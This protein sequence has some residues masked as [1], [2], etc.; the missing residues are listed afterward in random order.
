MFSESEE[1]LMLYMRVLSDARERSD[2]PLGISRVKPA[3]DLPLAEDIALDCQTQ[4]ADSHFDDERLNVS[5][6]LFSSTKFDDSVC[7]KIIFEEAKYSNQIEGIFCEEENYKLAKLISSLINETSELNLE[8]LIRLDGFIVGRGI[9]QKSKSTTRIVG[10]RGVVFTPPDDNKT[11]VKLLLDWFH[12]NNSY[13]R[14]NSLSLTAF[15]ALSHYQFESIHPLYDGNGRIGRALLLVMFMKHTN[16]STIPCLSH[17]IFKR[18]QEYY[19]CLNAPRFKGDF[20][21]LCGLFSDLFK[22][23]IAESFCHIPG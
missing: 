16:A 19:E 13:R 22:D 9:R 17:Q 18:K 3:N 15:L 7:K 21:M 4:L 12:F 6:E 1:E 2:N 20:T 8:L 11:I 23:A 10:K 14:Q 5:V